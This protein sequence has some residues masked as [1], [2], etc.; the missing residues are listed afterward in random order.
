MIPPEIITLGTTVIE[1]AVKQTGI[2]DK[3]RTRLGLDPVKRA[4]EVSLLAAMK[5]V[6]PDYPNLTSILF[7]IHFLTHGA[8][9]I[10]SQYI[11]GSR[12]PSAS[13][14]AQAWA[15][16]F[17][18][19]IGDADR[20]MATTA[21]E[22]YLKALER[23]LRKHDEFE[24]IYRGQ[25]IDK[26][27]SITTALQ[28]SPIGALSKANNLVRSAFRLGDDEAANFSYIRDP[29]SEQWQAA[30][31]FLTESQQHDKHSDVLLLLGAANSGKTR[32]AIESMSA[33]LPDW[34]VLPWHPDYSAAQIPPDLQLQDRDI[35]IFADDL[36]EY[37][38]HA[39][40]GSETFSVSTNLPAVTFQTLLDRVRACT[41]RTVVVATS[42]DE[43]ADDV[44][45]SLPYAMSQ[46]KIIYLPTFDPDRGKSQGI[47]DMLEARGARYPKEWDGTIGSVVLGLEKKRSQY[48]AFRN[49]P[50]GSV[51]RAMK[52]LTLARISQH[53]KS[54]IQLVRAKVFGDTPVGGDIRVWDDAVNEL[55]RSQFVTEDIRE[56]DKAPRLNIGK[57][58][59]LEHVIAD[60]PSKQRSKQL[61][62]H[63]AAL[64]TALLEAK[65]KEALVNLGVAYLDLQRFVDAEAVYADIL[66]LDPTMTMAWQNRANALFSMGRKVEALAASDRTIELDPENAVA[67]SNRCAI[68]AGLD[69][70]VEALESIER[71][72]TFDPQ[73]ETA[74]INHCSVLTKLGRAQ[75]AL[76]LLENVRESQQSTQLFW[77]NL[78]TTMLALGER[79]QALTAFERALEL[80]PSSIPCLSNK[81]AVL[82]ELRRFK[83]ALSLME[84]ISDESPG[85][86][87]I[88]SNRGK[89]YYE[90]GDLTASLD[91][92]DHALK[93]KPDLIEGLKGKAEVFIKLGWRGDALAVLENLVKLYP[94]NAHAWNHK[95]TT[96][97]KFDLY[98]K[99]AFSFEC[100]TTR[101]GTFSTAWNNKG[102]AL[103]KLGRLA[104]AADA[105][106]RACETDPSS[107]QASENLEKALAALSELSQNSKARFNISITDGSGSV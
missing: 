24:Y 58:S 105:F 87:M 3:I 26:L 88:W 73:N 86:E 93:L 44:F 33:A 52:L 15:A 35:V 100:A 89:I 41:H 10:L 74:T 84:G 27:S 79:E 83:E 46:A 92:F 36:H 38:S 1:F 61:D 103:S 94:E 4:L 62:Q 50:G 48:L 76:K 32:L 97:L 45:A 55:T 5:S 22:A 71:S 63:Y 102:V 28:A 99:A 54:R 7:D 96:E 37:V 90:L 39:Q 85:A 81:I 80:E 75:E 12:D 42:R 29:I 77:H 57:D 19:A 66:D 51:L 91:A 107:L 47:V 70:Y 69:R 9:P 67:W 2:L 59:Y 40:A 104:E 72:L 43:H 101:D 31:G 6:Q 98:E 60:Y 8:G 53:T 23:E 11:N 64:H 65:D 106:R 13:E 56:I 20:Q 95:G 21:A 30:A 18:Q 82:G 14:L 78:G 17:G 34:Y 68:L 25:V 16:Q 49:S